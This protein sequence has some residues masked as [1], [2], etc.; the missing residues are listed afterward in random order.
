LKVRF[1]VIARSETTKQSLC[2]EIA[3]PRLAGFAMTDCAKF[4]NA[5]LEPST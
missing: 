2:F 4:S 5:F 1:C 3:E